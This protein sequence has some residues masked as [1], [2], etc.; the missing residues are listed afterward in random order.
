VERYLR[1]RI[2]GLAELPAMI[3]CLPMG[4]AYARHHGGSRRPVMVAAV[5]HVEHGIV[6]AHRTWLTTDGSTKSSLDPVRVIKGPVKG[7]AV[8][9][10]PA[11]DRL[12]VGEGI[13]TCLSAMTATG[14]PAWA[15][16]S[17][18]GLSALVLPSIVQAVIILADNDQSGAGQRAAYAA[19]QRWLAEGRR[20]RIAM[21][22]EPGTDFND[23]LLGR[24]QGRPSEVRDV[25]A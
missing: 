5:E 10:A 18:S 15:A 25:A 22:P 1:A 4:N 6:A 12:M 16:L 14:M 20:V 3:G 23:A 7:G 9:L 21:P 17:T 13:E 24:T 2:P 8:R 19:A 11:V